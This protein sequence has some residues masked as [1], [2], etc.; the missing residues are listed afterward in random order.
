[1][2]QVVHGGAQARDIESDFSEASV[3]TL[4]LFPELNLR[5]RPDILAMKPGGTRVVSHGFGTGDWPPDADAYDRCHAQ[6][7][8]EWHGGRMP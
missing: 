7:V 8:P 1:V 4:Y 6:P 5:L 3:L 2:S